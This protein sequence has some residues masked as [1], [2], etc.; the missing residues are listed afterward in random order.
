M[1]LVAQPL[2]LPMITTQGLLGEEPAMLAELPLLSNMGTH[3]HHV[4]MPWMVQA[5]RA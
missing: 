5:W 3:S 2:K 1:A 4:D